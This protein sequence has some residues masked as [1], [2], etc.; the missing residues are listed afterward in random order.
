[1]T[2][3][4]FPKT[5][6]DESF[7]AE[8][9]VQKFID[10]VPLHRQAEA[11]ARDG[12]HVS[13][14]TLEDLIL[15]GAS[16]LTP[17]YRYHLEDVRGSPLLEADQTRLNIR[18]KGDDGV[19]RYVQGARSLSA[20]LRG[21]VAL[22][23]SADERKESCERVIGDKVEVLVSDAAA[24][25]SSIAGDRGIKEANCLSHA[26]RKLF[27]ARGADPVLAERA[28]DFFGAL[29]AVEALCDVKGVS[30]EQRRELRQQYARPVLCDFKLWCEKVAELRE[31]SEKLR[32]AIDYML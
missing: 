25:F 16:L 23:A 9:A 20:N 29:Y 14:D 31:K 27:Q 15:K 6:F 32:I 2:D 4:P 22:V 1:M 24:V 11:L 3:D 19:S 7:V 17:L 8:V 21:E 12:V 28:L 30:A 13:E 10:G 26:R 18:L 5:H